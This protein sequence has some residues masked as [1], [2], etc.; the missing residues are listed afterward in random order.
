MG[1]T[2]G[3]WTQE[4]RAGK[5]RRASILAGGFAMVSISTLAT[6][7]SDGLS[8]CRLL[9]ESAW[10]SVLSRFELP[11]VHWYVWLLWL[12]G[13]L[14]KYSGMCKAVFFFWRFSTSRCVA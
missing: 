10:S 1:S 4:K 9:V 12:Y 14:T 13:G 8:W 7:I 2:S 6:W 11:I 3:T 5:W